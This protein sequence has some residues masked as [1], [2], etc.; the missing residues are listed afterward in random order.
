[1]RQRAVVEEKKARE[2]LPA[3]QVWEKSF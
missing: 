1:M 2:E 3:E